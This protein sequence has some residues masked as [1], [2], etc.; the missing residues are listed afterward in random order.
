[1]SADSKDATPVAVEKSGTELRVEKSLAGIS[2]DVL[3]TRDGML[4]LAV[5]RADTRAV[6]RALRDNAG[7][8]TI[9]LVSAVDHLPRTPRFEVVHQ[10]LSLTHADRVRIKTQLKEVDAKIDSIVELYPGASFMERECFDMFGIEFN[11]HPDLRRLLMP[12]GYG[13][14]PL[15]KDFPHQG[16]EPDRLYREWDEKRRAAWDGEQR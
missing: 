6:I 7:F 3:E 11:D 5:E 9:T 10:L 15:R 4:T 1:M 13:H 8:E 12:E 16:I 2:Y 14:N